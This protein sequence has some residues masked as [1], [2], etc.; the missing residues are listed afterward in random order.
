MG[1]PLSSQVNPPLQQT[2]GPRFKGGAF[3]HVTP[4]I[5]T[6]VTCAIRAVHSGDGM[7]ADWVSLPYEVL[8]R[9]SSRIVNK[10]RGIN[11][12]VYDITS[13]APGT[14]EWE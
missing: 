5:M 3:H 11:S 1:L 8:K 9:I 4:R 2:P 14:I 13:K 10:I 6:E 7:T 12:V